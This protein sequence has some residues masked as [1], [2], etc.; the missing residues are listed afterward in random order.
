M[1][2]TLD[3]QE[4]EAFYETRADEFGEQA[5]VGGIGKLV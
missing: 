4:E 5:E 2:P 1:R 3:C